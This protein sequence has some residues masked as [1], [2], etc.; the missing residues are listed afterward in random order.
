MS[1]RARWG[2]LPIT[3]STRL[4]PPSAKEVHV[5]TLRILVLIS[6]IILLSP[7]V[8]A[9]QDTDEDHYSCYAGRGR[10]ARYLRGYTIAVA[11][12]E[13][14]NQFIDQCNATVTDSTGRIVFQVHDHG[15]AIDS[16]TGSDLDGDG[17]PETVLQGYSGGAHCC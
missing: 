5:N 17:Y 15:M 8:Q 14:Q 16:V 2:A 1:N 13:N 11:P 12:Y 9:A 10:A 7:T 6:G 3:P 4:N